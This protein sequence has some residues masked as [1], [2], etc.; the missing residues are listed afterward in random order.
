M[1]RSRAV[2]HMRM[3]CVR[4]SNRRVGSAG[5]L[6]ATAYFERIVREAG[7]EAQVEEFAC[8]D[9]Q[10]RGVT[11]V[12]GGDT[13]Q[14]LSSPYSLG[15]EVSARLVA[16]ATLDE[17]GSADA[18]GAVLLLRGDLARE[19]VM[20]KE[21]PFYNPEHHQALI[22]LLEQKRPAAIIAAT[23][24]DP[25]MVGS[26][27]PFPVFEDGD[28]D[29][30]S[31]YMTRAEG[32]R[33]IDR[34]AGAVRL[35]SRA[36]RIP[37]RGEQVT[38]RRGLIQSPRVVFL[39]HIDTRMGTPGANDNASGIATLL[40]L[41]ELLSVYA[42]GLGIEIVA[43]N[44]EDYY[45]ANGERL[46]VAA[47]EGRFGEIALGIN[48]DDVGYRKGR[49]AYSLYG[50]PDEIGRAIHSV[51]AECETATEG[52]AWYQGDHMLFVANQVP[53]IAVTDELYRELMAEIT[54]TAR[55]TVDAI[56][57]R[58]IANLAVAL[59]DLVLLLSEAGL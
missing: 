1:L 14:A 58:K 18:E 46:F 2:E 16:V 38:A 45:G 20:P 59:R 50:C 10:T 6:A 42:G 56:D 54:H 23:T 15:C 48:L 33:L 57:P 47:N 28:F 39:A 37:S 43:I 25:V 21:F 51:F 11:L 24:R 55:D 52:E 4:I 26:Q 41:A 3:L 32:E 13:F 30:P 17:L 8:I 19:Q 29:I 40:L 12:A 34:A 27:Y 49:S 35:K 36:A 7:F 44:G 9:W 31:V 22:R 5:N 53:A